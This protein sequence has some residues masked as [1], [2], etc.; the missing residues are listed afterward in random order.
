MCKD[1]DL[2]VG[3]SKEDYAERILAPEMSPTKLRA[4][5]VS[6][7]C[8]MCEE[9]GLKASE[10][11]LKDDLVDR[12]IAAE[13]AKTAKQPSAAVEAPASEVG[14]CVLSAKTLS[15]LQQLCA[16]LGLRQQGSQQ[17]LAQRLAFAQPLLKLSRTALSA[18]PIEELKQL[19]AGLDLHKQGTEEQL[20]ER[21][22]APALSETKLC[23]RTA[24][25][26][27]RMCRE[28][29]LRGNEKDRE[30]KRELIDRL[31]AHEEAKDANQPAAAGGSS[32]KSAA[33]GSKAC[34][35]AKSAV[36][37]VGE[38]RIFP[39]IVAAGGPPAAVKQGFSSSSGAAPAAI[40]AAAIPAAPAVPPASRGNKFTKEELTAMK[41]RPELED[42]CRKCRVS[43]KNENRNRLPKAQITE[44]LFA[45]GVTKESKSS[46][47]SSGENQKTPANLAAAPSAA[48]A[49]VRQ[50]PPLAPGKM[51][52]EEL[53]AL[54]KKDLE[55]L[56]RDNAVPSAGSGKKASH[57][58]STAAPAK[59]PEEAPLGGAA[60]AVGDPKPAAGASANNAARQQ[61][62]MKELTAM[63]RIF[64]SSFSSA[65]PQSGSF[66]GCGNCS[67]SRRELLWNQNDEAG[68][69]V[70]NFSFWRAQKN[71]IGHDGSWQQ[72]Q[73]GPCTGDIRCL[74]KSELVEKLL[75]K[76]ATKAKESVE[77]AT[78]NAFGGVSAAPEQLATSSSGT[79]TTREGLEA[80]KKDDLLQ[81]C[82]QRSL[83]TAGRAGA[84]S[85]QGLADQLLDE[86]VAKDDMPRPQQIAGTNA[87]ADIG[88]A[89]SSIASAGAPGHE[90]ANAIANGSVAAKQV[91]GTTIREETAAIKQQSV[92]NAIK[93]E[94]EVVA[95]CKR[96]AASLSLPE[97]SP[98]GGAGRELLGADQNA[99]EE[100]ALSS[101]TAGAVGPDQSAVGGTGTGSKFR[102]PPTAGTV[103]PDAGSAGSG[104]AGCDE[105][106]SCSSGGER[107]LTAAIAQNADAV[108][109]TGTGSKAPDAGSAGRGGSDE[110]PN[111]VG[112][113]R[114][115]L[116]VCGNDPVAEKERD[117]D[118]FCGSNVDAAWEVERHSLLED[119]ETNSDIRRKATGVGPTEAGEAATTV[120]V[121]KKTKKK[122]KKKSKED[123]S[124]R[125]ACSA[126]GG[127][128]EENESKK[129][130]KKQS[131][132]KERK[133]EKK[134]RR[135]EELLRDHSCDPQPE[136]A[137]ATTNICS[138]PAFSTAGST[139]ARETSELCTAT[140][141]SALTKVQLE[142]LCRN[143][144]LPCYVQGKPRRGHTRL[145][146]EDMEAQLL[147][148]GVLKN[149]VQ[150]AAAGPFAVCSEDPE[151][152]GR[153][154]VTKAAESSDSL[155]SL[156]QQQ[157]ELERELTKMVAQFD[158]ENESEKRRPQEEPGWKYRLGDLA[159]FLWRDHVTLD[160]CELKTVEG[161]LLKLEVSYGR[162]KGRP[163]QASVGELKWLW[164]WQ[165]AE[166][167]KKLRQVDAIAQKVVVRAAAQQKPAKRKK[168]KK[169]AA[170][171]Q[172]DDLLADEAEECTS[173]DDDDGHPDDGRQALLSRSHDIPIVAREEEP[174][175]ALVESSNVEAAA[176][177]GGEGQ[178][179]CRQQPKELLHAMPPPSED[180]DE[181]EEED[182]YC[183]A[184]EETRTSSAAFRERQRVEKLDARL[185]KLL[186]CGELGPG[187]VPNPWTRQRLA[188]E[189]TRDA[190]PWVR[191]KL[192]G[193]A[194]NGTAA[195]PRAALQKVR[196]RRRWCEE[197][198]ASKQKGKAVGSYAHRELVL[199]PRDRKQGLGRGKRRGQK[200]LIKLGKTVKPLTRAL[201]RIAL[202]A[203]RLRRQEE[204]LRRLQTDSRAETKQWKTQ[205]RRFAKRRAAALR[206]QY[207][208]D[209]FHPLPPLVQ[210][211][212]CQ[213][214][215]PGLACRIPLTEGDATF[216][217]S[218]FAADALPFAKRLQQ[219]VRAPRLKCL[220]N[221]AAKPLVEFAA[222]SIA[223]LAE[224]IPLVGEVAC[225]GAG[226]LEARMWREGDGHFREMC[227]GVDRGPDS[228]LDE[229]A[230]LVGS[231]P[232]P[233]L[234]PE[235]GYHTPGTA[236]AEVEVV[237]AAPTP[238]PAASG[239]QQSRDHA[240]AEVARLKAK[241]DYAHVATDVLD[242]ELVAL[243]TSGK[244]SMSDVVELAGW[245]A[246]EL[247]ED[248]LPLVQEFERE[249]GSL[250]NTSE[251]ADAAFLRLIDADLCE[252]KTEPDAGEDASLDAFQQRSENFR[253]AKKKFDEAGASSFDLRVPA[254]FGTS[255][256]VHHQSSHKLD[257]AAST[258][259]AAFIPSKPSKTSS[260]K[261]KKS[262]KADDALLLGQDNPE[263]VH[264]H[265]LVSRTAPGLA[266]VPHTSPLLVQKELE[267]F[268]SSDIRV[269]K[270][271][272]RY[273]GTTFPGPVE[274]LFE[275]QSALEKLG[276][277]G[278]MTIRRMVGSIL[279][280][281]R[282]RA[283]FKF[284]A[285]FYKLRT[286]ATLLGFAQA[287]EK[288][289]EVLTTADESSQ[290]VGGG[291]MWSVVELL[292]GYLCAEVGLPELQK[293]SNQL[294]L[295]F[296]ES[297]IRGM[298]RA[299][300]LEAHMLLLE[301]ADVAPLYNGCSLAEFESLVPTSE[302]AR[303]RRIQVIMEKRGGP[304][305]P[306]SA[307]TNPLST[308]STDC[309][310]KRPRPRRQAKADV[311][312]PRDANGEAG[313]EENKDIIRHKKS[314]PELEKPQ[315]IDSQQCVSSSSSS[316]H[317]RHAKRSHHGVAGW[318]A[319][320]VATVRKSGGL[321]QKSV[322]KR[323]DFGLSPLM[324][325]SSKM[326]H[327]REELMFRDAFAVGQGS[328][329]ISTARRTRLA[330]KRANEA[331]PPDL[332]IYWS[333]RIARV[334]RQK[335]ERLA[336]GM[337]SATP[338]A[339]AYWL[340]MQGGRNRAL[341]ALAT[342][343][344]PAP[345]TDCYMHN[346]KSRRCLDP[347]L[348]VSTPSFD[349]TVVATLY[350]LA[351][352][353]SLISFDFT[354]DQRK[355]LEKLCRKRTRTVARRIA[356]GRRLSNKEP[357]RSCFLLREAWLDA[358]FE[359]GDVVGASEKPPGVTL[360]EGF[361]ARRKKREAR[362]VAK[363]KKLA[364]RWKVK[365]KQRRN[366]RAKANPKYWTLV[367][368]GETELSDGELHQNGIG[369]GVGW[370]A[371]ANEQHAC[372]SKRLNKVKGGKICKKLQDQR[373]EQPA[374]CVLAPGRRPL[375]RVL[376]VPSAL[377]EDRG[378]DNVLVQ[379]ARG[380]HICVAE[381]YAFEFQDAYTVVRK[382][383]GKEIADHAF[384]K[385]TPVVWTSAYNNHGG[386]D[387]V[388]KALLKICCLAPR[389]L[390]IFSQELHA[391]RFFSAEADVRMVRQAVKR[392][393]EIP[394]YGDFHTKEFMLT[395][396]TFQRIVC[397]RAAKKCEA[398][399]ACLDMAGPGAEKGQRIMRQLLK[400]AGCHMV[401][402]LGINLDGVMGLFAAVMSLLLRIVNGVNCDDIQGVQWLCC[403]FSKLQLFPRETTQAYKRSRALASATEKDF[404]TLL[405]PPLRL[406][407]L[408]PHLREA[409]R[410]KY[411][412]GS[413][414]PSLIAY[415]F[416]RLRKH[417]TLHLTKP[418]RQ[419]KPT[420]AH[421]DEQEVESDDAR[422]L[423]RGEDHAGVIRGKSDGADAD[424]TPVNKGSDLRALPLLSPDEIAAEFERLEKMTEAMF[425]KE[426]LFERVDLDL[427]ECHRPT[428][429]QRKH[430]PNSCPW[431][432]EE[433]ERLEGLKPHQGDLATSDAVLCNIHNPAVARWWVEH[434]LAPPLNDDELLP[435]RNTVR[436]EREVESLFDKEM[437]AGRKRRRKL[438]PFRR[439]KEQ[440]A[441]EAKII[442]GGGDAGKRQRIFQLAQKSF[443]EWGKGDWNL[444]EC[445]RNAVYPLGRYA[446]FLLRVLERRLENFLQSEAGLVL[447]EPK[448]LIETVIAA[449]FGQEVE[450]GD[451]LLAVVPFGSNEGCNVVP[452]DH[453]GDRNAEAEVARSN[454]LRASIKNLGG[455]KDCLRFRVAFPWFK[456]WA[457][458]S[459][460]DG[461]KLPQNLD[462]KVVAAAKMV[463]ALRAGFFLHIERKRKLP[464]LCEVADAMTECFEKLP[465]ARLTASD[466]AISPSGGGGVLGAVVGAGKSEFDG[467]KNSVSGLRQ[468]QVVLTKDADNAAAFGREP[469]SMVPD[470][471]HLGL[472][473]EPLPLAKDEY[474]DSAA[475]FGR[476]PA[477]MM[478]DSLHLGLPD[479]KPPAEKSFPDGDENSVSGLPQCQPVLAKDEYEDAFK[480][481][482]GR[483]LAL[484][485]RWDSAA[486]FERE[487][488]SMVP[489]G[490]HLGLPEGDPADEWFSDIDSNEDCL[491]D[492]QEQLHTMPGIEDDRMDHNYLKVAK[493]E[494]EECVD[495]LLRNYVCS[496][497]QER[498]KR[499]V[500]AE[501]RRQGL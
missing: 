492:E 57:A 378:H 31:L 268:C 440:R 394:E 450:V 310:K 54:S 467:D 122:A 314:C 148:K 360:L 146:K 237:G 94:V 186:L 322:R 115:D 491:L 230:P 375:Y 449:E 86:G 390:L 155:E 231:G 372:K 161:R 244:L 489:D 248:A 328:R 441:Y 499:S 166:L 485:P 81:M 96:A 213:A 223:E 389:T 45:A 291:E 380:K 336:T 471:L 53:S 66:S 51:T 221:N 484:Q 335:R 487:L 171:D 41:L 211:A 172:E 462:P 490:L 212:L 501:L 190:D 404:K 152:G 153:D 460:R 145:K 475:A 100:A 215:V 264:F 293:M 77:P 349:N 50:H 327:A 187:V 312:A 330:R 339:I 113:L 465:G 253:G 326:A 453:N 116:L 103:D 167:R 443:E 472:P 496:S 21:I 466:D 178:N 75:A 434:F 102:V 32:S 129:H 364:A 257:P 71:C 281:L 176:D 5:R 7:L 353:M 239:T 91:E 431:A 447:T 139:S 258:R 9:R 24:S 150:E 315:L 119:A 147:A 44:K 12:L 8:R 87:N 355:L 60:A 209:N 111:S 90:S 381:F 342:E 457:R 177:A 121:E 173:D 289:N 92:L 28:R 266:D 17:E 458:F 396:Q 477:S 337:A 6:Y 222:D 250:S 27:C 304:V 25:Y 402:K 56:C 151:H 480:R 137:D 78:E 400:R 393:R 495:R 406:D 246:E 254:S 169:K 34:D 16:D 208:R 4:R 198:V 413:R 279:Q 191:E 433:K 135:E 395:L 95:P 3:G 296:F 287:C 332:G 278:C 414:I 214:I 430:T 463:I 236:T 37:V 426:N 69:I 123:H 227:R 179:I 476:E 68:A 418:Q 347:A 382:L 88:K 456:G 49:S 127:R 424:K 411:E 141:L 218:G 493:D 384:N 42:L 109:G 163:R 26:L 445:A 20:A 370:K 271:H 331:M 202:D 85:K 494:M 432:K 159:M 321:K 195:D 362:R 483:E 368:G 110:A 43:Y 144:G 325:S 76:G 352:K 162:H 235:Q 446:V 38:S 283:V 270:R 363:W 83:K 234:V 58:C 52:K 128:D 118:N 225:G 448:T 297:T 416:R 350:N 184:E 206:E 486:A 398:A 403:V 500:V 241:F 120:L 133:A 295:R 324:S 189:I 265:S 419:Y 405:A 99:V 261:N 89:S 358:E 233:L 319:N 67:G 149:D 377:H 461:V 33:A 354:R 302:A 469:A 422:E 138:A 385:K 260:N 288:G 130:G 417:N 197:R 245:S 437:F 316:S 408:L 228:S 220:Q 142:R 168:K 383:L 300:N 481:V 23:A 132:K 19:C 224:H 341:R 2:Q 107:K 106:S 269:E 182:F 188:K 112:E 229:S 136:E 117:R 61:F 379:R 73:Q 470:S 399:F 290:A 345:A 74:R 313:A 35:A 30:T 22:L 204:R 156:K 207:A 79:K 252:D 175:R 366:K 498:V 256:P 194:E 263:F 183:S 423:N 435:T 165:A 285:S 277:P 371:V 429:G 29:G 356:R 46:S 410:W 451:G 65:A 181:S 348:N 193:Q 47:A 415:V 334:Q 259:D 238:S 14:A 39:E 357:W 158:A 317:T 205:I 318:K 272:V 199:L 192:R 240:A 282:A 62:T 425:E 84:L 15:Q 217:L 216:F 164:P 367:T 108:G 267:R 391:S 387:G 243:C 1:M 210:A 226:A 180:D 333:Y 468:C 251:Q 97:Q 80:L 101:A 309:G 473:D 442:D 124:E 338:R 36:G 104:G 140:E 59:A 427:V 275:E 340:R 428:V 201:N 131:K 412:E 388:L 303:E 203:A 114:E 439:S 305:P 247:M 479:Y 299:S 306:C 365:M 93:Y 343:A 286:G 18:K 407:V 105:A 292:G 474:E 397:P 409:A 351:T 249:F 436:L 157:A 488:P 482:L 48:S 40:A 361:L 392:V 276:L 284:A 359:D 464:D 373:P 311:W 134:R 452:Y 72:Q 125:E 454:K 323:T 185:R 307:S 298:D 273:H 444:Y 242:E 420:L 478:P 274:I 98:E 200:T 219:R 82:R 255:A 143:L 196:A 301:A 308:L 13:Q 344:P 160:L 346:W 262:E 459:T 154:L 63:R 455:E 376:R 320:R 438:P 497:M 11:E 55:E 280:L 232:A 374:V 64:V 126:G 10:L 386:A 170:D 401:A 421:I 369:K 329:W 174:R 294:R 70:F